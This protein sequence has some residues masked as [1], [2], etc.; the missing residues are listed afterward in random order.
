MRCAH[1]AIWLRDKANIHPAGF[2]VDFLSTFHHRIDN[3]H[4]S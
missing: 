1:L 2:V 4:H 3:S